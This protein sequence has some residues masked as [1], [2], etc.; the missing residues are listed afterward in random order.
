MSRVDEFLDLYRALELEVSSRYDLPSDQ[1]TIQSLLS[2]REFSRYRNVIEYCRDIRNLLSHNPKIENEYAVEPSAAIVEALRRVLKRV[3]LHET[4]LMCSTRI[5]DALT[6]SM[7]D[8][9]LPVMEEMHRRGFSHV[10]ILKKGRVEGVFS[11]AT[12]FSCVLD[13]AVDSIS[14]KTRFNDLF[15]YLPISSRKKPRFGFVARNAP[16]LESERLL[17]D[18]FDAGK[19]IDMLFVTENGKETESVLGLLTPWDILGREF[20]D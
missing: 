16:V 4:N 19:R 5:E 7:D 9:V 3:Q 12:I 20:D 15:S 8:F 6:A 10:P 2:K 14:E 13:D 11:E 18:L 1:R 17:R